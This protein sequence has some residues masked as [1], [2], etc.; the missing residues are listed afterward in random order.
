MKHLLILILLIPHIIHASDITT[1][2]EKNAAALSSCS[3][4]QPCMVSVRDTEDGHSAK[5]TKCVLITEY[6]V[7]KFLPGGV[8]YYI[9]DINGK[10]L[11]THRTP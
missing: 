3:A 11:R 4:D 2:I 1:E 6:G 8:T 5:V 10:L 9:F 7:L